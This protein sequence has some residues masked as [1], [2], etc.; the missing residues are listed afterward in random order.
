MTVCKALVDAMASCTKIQVLTLRCTGLVNRNQ[1]LDNF[2]ELPAIEKLIVNAIPLFTDTFLIRIINHGPLLSYIDISGIWVS[3]LFVEW[4]YCER[5]N[6]FVVVFIDCQN[7][8]DTGLQTLSILPNLETLIINDLRELN[9][10]GL[11]LFSGTKLRHLECQRCHSIP[12]EPFCDVL[13]QCPNLKFLNVFECTKIDER[14]IDTAFKVTSQR[15]NHIVL[16]MISNMK[17]LL[18]T[19]MTTPPLLDLIMVNNW[20]V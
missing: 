2:I 14:V 18:I 5:G 10:A 19:R 20:E 17:F 3:I 9:G 15:D 1:F 13:N 7:L 6:R 11:S 16:K 12:S 8:T 4:F